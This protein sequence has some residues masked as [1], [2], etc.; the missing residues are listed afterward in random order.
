MVPTRE[1]SVAASLAAARAARAARAAA[2]EVGGATDG[3]SGTTTQG[4]DD[5]ALGGEGRRR[6]SASHPA[7]AAVDRGATPWARVGWT[8]ASKG[9]AL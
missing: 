3:A 5:R 4:L 7:A 8:V 2:R 9:S 6:A 1:G